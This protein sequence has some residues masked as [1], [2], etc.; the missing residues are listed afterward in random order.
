MATPFHCPWPQWAAS[1]PSAANAIEGKL[2]SESLVS[3]RQSTSGSAYASHSSTRGIRLLRELMFQVATRTRRSLGVDGEHG[4]QASDL[5][6]PL[7][8]RARR[9]QNELATTL[10][11]PLVRPDQ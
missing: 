8:G 6:H 5:Q 2:V 4:V 11:Q 7:G 1:Y 3:W 10:T 9:P